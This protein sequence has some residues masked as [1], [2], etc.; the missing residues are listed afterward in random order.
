MPPPGAA[1]C[2]WWRCGARIMRRSPTPRC[3]PSFSNA[4]WAACSTTS[5]VTS[6]AAA[7]VIWTGT[8]RVPSGTRPG[9]TRSAGSSSPGVAST[10]SWGRCSSGSSRCWTGWRRS[11]VT[12]PG[13]CF[14][15]RGAGGG[16]ATEVGV[17]RLRAGISIPGVEV[18]LAHEA[19]HRVL[20]VFRGADLSPLL[21]DTDPQKVG[22]AARRPHGRHARRRPHRRGGGRVRPPGPGPA[23]RPAPGQ[24][25][26][27]AGLR[28]PAPAAL[29]ARALRRAVG[30]HRRLPDV[31]GRRQPGGDGRRCP[32]RPTSTRSW[33]SCASTG[34]TTTTSSSTTSRTDSAGEDGN[35]E[36]KVAAIEALDAAI[37]EI[38]AMGPDVLA[39]HRRPRHARARWRPTPGTRCRCSCGAPR[40]GRDDQTRFGERWCLHGALGRRPGQDLM[41]HGPRR[42]RPPG[43]VRRL[44]RPNRRR[45]RRPSDRGRAVDGSADGVEVAAAE[46][47]EVDGHPR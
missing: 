45:Q 37:P 47:L 22:V 11:T 16:T 18:I 25:R 15:R 29:D 41:P 35:F 46:A 19:Q 4:S 42:Q 3:T 34:T 26:P 13:P 17:V 30:G 36:A 27:P 14:R 1:P 10:P 9:G 40:I 32:G 28:L 7:T 33:P 20:V 12:S 39:R 2:S 24:R 38:A 5:R 21:A 6:S 43:Q 31:P 23:R 44:S 8:A